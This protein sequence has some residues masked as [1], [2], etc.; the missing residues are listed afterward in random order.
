M[1]SRFHTKWNMSPTVSCLEKANHKCGRELTRGS[2]HLGE[3]WTQAGVEAA[4]SRTALKVAGNWP[5]AG[6]TAGCAL[7]S[8]EGAVAVQALDPAAGTLSSTLKVSPGAG[9]AMPG[10]S[11]R[12]RMER[13]R[14][15]GC[16][17]GSTRGD[18]CTARECVS[19]G[20]RARVGAFLTLRD[21]D[22]EGPRD[23]RARG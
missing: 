23:P 19:H 21:Q 8:S 16:R 9:R 5:R 15:Q 11:L 14:Q 3:L 6:G 4:L 2:L 18:Q 17:P 13:P 7:V 22:S 10:P 12:C 1:E 20:E